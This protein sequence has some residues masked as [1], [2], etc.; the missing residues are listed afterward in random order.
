MQ[1]E[2]PELRF[3]FDLNCLGKTRTLI[4]NIFCLLLLILVPIGWQSTGNAQQID[5]ITVCSNPAQYSIG[6]GF[7]SS[8]DDK[9]LNKGNF[10]PEG[11][12]AT[13]IEHK[14]I[15][16]PVTQLVLDSAGCDI[17][18]I[19]ATESDGGTGT[20]FFGLPDADVQEIYEW[21]IANSSNVVFVPQGFTTRWGG[22]SAD[23]GALNPMVATD[24]GK[25]VAFDGPFGFVFDGFNQGG[26][27]RGF[28]Q[29]TPEDSFCPLML[30]SSTEQ[31][32][33][34]LFDTKS[35]DFLYSDVDI[36][37]SLGG[38]TTG[39]E[40][41]SNN[42]IVL[43]NLYALAVSIVKEGPP[44]VCE[45]IIPVEENTAP[46]CD[47]GGP[48]FSNVNTNGTVL[49][50]SGAESVDPDGDELTYYWSTNN[51]NAAFTDILSNS[52]ELVFN[53]TAGICEEQFELVLNV[54]DGKAVESCNTHVY[55][56]DVSDSSLELSCQDLTLWPP[57][58]NLTPAGFSY[59]FKGCNSSEAA[60]DNVN[61]EIW[62]NEPEYTAKGGGDGKH[63]PDAKYFDQCLSVR[64]ERSGKGNGRV[65]LISATAGENTAVNQKSYCTVTVPKSK[66]KKHIDSIK[67]DAAD[68]V[69]YLNTNI[70]ATPEDLG[71]ELHGQSALIG[72][73]QSLDG[74]VD[75]CTVPGGTPINNK[76]VIVS[77]PMISATPEN[78]YT[79][80]VF[81]TDPESQPIN[82]S[83]SVSPTGMSIDS[84]NG[85][86]SWQP[87]ENQKG[88]HEITVIA[89]DPLGL[90]DVQTYFIVV[91]NKVNVAPIITSQP[92][93]SIPEGEMY[94]Y[95][96]KAIDLDSDS[97]KY[98][99]IVKPTG[100][101]IDSE[102]GAINWI[103][104]TNQSG[105]NLV[106]IAVCDSFDNC[107]EQTFS[108]EVEDALNTPPVII[109]T[110]IT[111]ATEN[112]IYE[113]DVVVEDADQDT[114]NFLLID[115]PTGMSINVL[116]G[117]I[118]WTPVIGQSGEQS[119]KVEVSDGS[120]GIASQEFTIVVSGA[121][122]QAPTITSTP[123]LVATVAIDYNYQVQ[124]SAPDPNTILT[125]SLSQFPEG[126]QIDSVSGIITWTPDPTQV[127]SVDVVVSVADGTVEVTQPFAI[128]VSID[129]IATAVV[130]CQIDSPI[131]GIEI[132]SLTPVLGSLSAATLGA[133][134]GEPLNWTILL[135]TSEDPAGRILRTGTG[136]LPNGTVVNLDPT[137][138]QNN[139]YT[140]AITYEQGT[141]SG[142][143]TV[144]FTISSDL[145]VGNFRL[146]LV[147]L[148]VPVAGTPIVISRTYD[149]LDLSLGEFGQGWRIGY[150][151]SV[152]ETDATGNFNPGETKV[153]VTKPD[154][155][156]SAF[157]FDVVGEGG[158]FGAI[159]QRAV[160]T[161][162][163]GTYDTLEVDGDNLLTALNIFNPD[164]Y[165]LTE[166]NGTEFIIDQFVGI[167]SIE[168]P[169][170]N[171]TTFDTN[172]ITHSS[173]TEITFQ[174]DN[175]GRI[176][177]II[178]P[179]GNS[180]LYSY[181]S[182]GDL[183][184]VTDR[185]GDTT[186]YTY[187]DE[188]EHFLETIVDN[189]N[190]AIFEAEF[191]AN[192]RVLSTSDA[193]GNTVS[194]NFDPATNTLISTDAKG[195]ITRFVV[196]SFGNILTETDP[197]G[198][199][200]TY[201]YDDPRHPTRE[202]SITDA[203]GN[204]TTI[205]Y[206][207]NG[208]LAT[209]T[210]P[211]GK[212]SQF[213]F[214]E[215]DELER[216]EDSLGAVT[217]YTNT[218][219]LITTIMNPLGDTISITYN[220]DGTVQ[221]LTDFEGNTTTF[222]YDGV[223][224]CGQPTKVINP[225]GTERN[226]TYDS[227]GQLLVI[228]DELGHQR[229]FEYFDDGL[230][231]SETD[232]EGHTT[233]YTYQNG[234]RVTET[235]PLG[236]VRTFTY[237]DNGLLNTEVS[238]TG[239]TVTRTYDANGN[240]ETLT[241]PVGN[242]TQFAY[243]GNNRLIERIDPLGN[244]E[245][246]SYD[247]VGNRT[248]HTDRNGRERTF[249]Y[250][251]FNQLV[252]EQWLDGNGS[253]FFSYTYTYDMVGRTTSISSS[254][255]RLDFTYDLAGNLSTET[256]TRGSEVFILSY[257][258][259]KNGLE[260]K[261]SD[262]LGWEIETGYD[263]LSSLSE[264]IWRNTGAEVGRVAFGYNPRRDLS[265]IER[266]AAGDTSNSV[267]QTVYDLHDQ[268]RLFGRIS[269]QTSDG[270]VI[271]NKEFIRT[272][273][274]L[275]Q[276]A[277]AS[278]DG[279]NSSYNYDLDG[280]LTSVVND[281]LPDE[282][283]L[284]D[285]NGNRL[286]SHLHGSAYETG[287]NNQLLSDGENTYQYDSEGNLISKASLIG[288]TSFSF[289]WD[290]RNRLTSI[291]GNDGSFLSIG[292]DGNDRRIT[293]SDGT[294][295]LESLQYDGDNRWSQ[296]ASDG[297]QTN[298]LFGEDI[299][300][301][302]AESGN[303]GLNWFLVS[304]QKST[305]GS[306][307]SNNTVISSRQYDSFGNNFGDLLS[308]SD[309]GFTG[310]EYF[311]LTDQYYFRSRF[312]QPDIGRFVGEDQIGFEGRDSNLYRFLGNNPVTGTDPL[313]EISSVEKALLVGNILSIA[314]VA[315]DTICNNPLAGANEPIECDNRLSELGPV[316]DLIGNPAAGSLG[317]IQN[318]VRFTFIQLID[319]LS[320]ANQ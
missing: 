170:G 249:V 159:V 160:F 271:D 168:D 275:N 75:A 76:P 81:A 87:T 197:E 121:P 31:K 10:G 7:M 246:F 222:E 308:I 43:L 152:R 248:S 91:K 144:D 137:L 298:F 221:T 279:N 188:P 245:T 181:D 102:S 28:L 277:T 38:V 312:Y 138:L 19:G 309:F 261:V 310:R 5:L 313:G 32:L 126:M 297:N 229:T 30:D 101:V 198:G 94:A 50:I 130:I 103:P 27:W 289:E 60:S 23:A 11:I 228:Q 36:L 190:T 263:A 133:D 300:T 89:E 259:N 149:T 177:Q 187:L 116:S 195:N 304:H 161:P 97:I 173:G 56:K 282:S 316:L 134:A 46:I 67:K 88:I 83:F 86:I 96:V 219:G 42:D 13:S 269:H 238:P 180:I 18:H 315:Q 135:S 244:A 253:V 247:P 250:D 122:S 227:N 210:N 155:S 29:T 118:S 276:V 48:Y 72:P 127:G 264:R 232:E 203:N 317:V 285:L 234:L 268:R 272:Y 217:Q 63:A 105:E 156:V 184:S 119:V 92:L 129:G 85:L 35:G 206:D 73:K 169:S 150:P 242:I 54:T 106:T 151:G 283:Y 294:N 61:V 66:S 205:A 12:V 295:S 58:H 25:R 148:N 64:N 225:D 192:G 174:R 319:I 178:D 213:T 153:Y 115:P 252:E 141:Q 286:S 16:S 147:D 280:Q 231:M 84:E 65:Y 194:Q 41:S 212:T 208:N 256:D 235:D 143:C 267:N 69:S 209:T 288:E 278:S 175:Q 109:S 281:V 200:R 78:D 258:N 24:Y 220:T 270:S 202:T 274:E 113:Y 239:A 99:L 125:Y 301:N 215:G 128:D 240:L 305:V 157:T 120:G 257:D 290:Y 112:T 117:K 284:Y 306:V 145:K 158:L 57:N 262:N 110:P 123:N 307:D 172:G 230:L 114:L 136:S 193:L 163:P 140:V 266:F 167:Q 59:A 207:E 255:G 44:E 293:L 171:I 26:R 90:A 214:N 70:G 154:G 189:Q 251:A 185:D 226:L 211:L 162:D 21:S 93:L 292:Y 15:E 320:A 20:Q 196:D 237:F 131:E 318:Q 98:D 296:L 124:A 243:D 55:I 62:S 311:P 218:N 3:K 49:A 254:D 1:T 77:T 287:L 224:G 79:Y 6:Q 165:K 303:G 260:T 299:D 216:F 53:R 186:S 166:P 146:D 4:S 40:V 71:L 302:L 139:R 233:S 51:D 108:I 34:G 45:F 39:E 104:S 183:I 176:Q 9:L 80:Q 179:E 95:D 2:R 142:S 204:T 164:R 14:I 52:P 265:L 111:A 17:F 74:D 314:S 182:D 8:V 132:T 236:N 82:Y 191:D 107:S 199:I 22:Y 223:C 37:T 100:M 273:N 291:S 241:D 47:A 201:Q 68:I 33:V